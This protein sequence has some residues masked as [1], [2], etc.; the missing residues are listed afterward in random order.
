MLSHKTWRLITY[1]RALYAATESCDRAVQA[2]L[3]VISSLPLLTV[4]ESCDRAVQA[5]LDRFAQL[6]RSSET[7]T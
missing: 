4:T 6:D 7:P 2:R 1:N 5:I 3:Y